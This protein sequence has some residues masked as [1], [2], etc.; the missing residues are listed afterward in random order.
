LLSHLTARE[1]RNLAPLAWQPA[2]GGH[3]LTGGNGAGKSSVMEAIYVLATTRSFRTAQLGDCRRHG[4]RGFWLT[5]EVSAGRRA[6]LQLSWTSEGLKRSVN[7][8]TASLA[9]HLAV[10]PVVVWTTADA[11]LWTGSPQLRRRQMDRGVLGVRPAALEVISRYRKALAQ[12]RQLLQDRVSGERMAVWN[13]VLAAAAA[14]LIRWRADYVRRLS[15]ALAETLADSGLDL[16]AIELVYRPSPPRSKTSPAEELPT[17]SPAAIEEQLAR[18]LREELRRRQPLVGPHRD[19][20]AVRWQ[21]HILRKVASAGERKALGMLTAAAHGRVLA[22]RDRRP[23]YL[24]DD[25]DAE[26]ARPTLHAVWKAFANVGQLFAS[27]NRPEVWEGIEVGQ[28]WQLSKG[29]LSA[30]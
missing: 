15:A 13:G 3:L 9:E 21:G 28:R 2:A 7:G 20:L 1:F 24:L 26:L 29:V 5:G 10:L 14:E 30:A 12:K 16:P 23:I 4:A 22:A 8:K 6:A 11:D 19:D 25:A 17:P 27:S 18:A